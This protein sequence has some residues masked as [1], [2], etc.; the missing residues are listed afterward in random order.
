MANF[1]ETFDQL[2]TLWAQFSEQHNGKT[3]KAKKEA[4]QTLNEFKKLITPYRKL[5][6]EA[7][8]IKE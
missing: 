8:K 7:A 3:K 5:S 1:D 6:V 2:S 4:R